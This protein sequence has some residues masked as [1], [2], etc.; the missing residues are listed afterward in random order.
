MTRLPTHTP[1]R[2]DANDRGAAT[3]ELVLLMPLLLL[4]LMFGVATAVAVW[5]LVRR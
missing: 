1:P 2:Q 4:M 3:V 5:T